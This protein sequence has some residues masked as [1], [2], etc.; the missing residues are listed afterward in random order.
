MSQKELKK[1]LIL[2]A[3]VKAMQATQFVNV[4][5]GQEVEGQKSINVQ[6]AGGWSFRVKEGDEY[7]DTVLKKI[8]RGQMLEIEMD[9][10]KIAPYQRTVTATDSGNEVS[11]TDYYRNIDDFKILSVGTTPIP[12][13]MKDV[14][15]AT[16]T[17]DFAR[18]KGKDFTQ[19]GG[20]GVGGAGTIDEAER[21]KDAL[22]DTSQ[23]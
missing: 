17:L 1:G 3:A 22:G 19:K 12:E 18:K 21:A 9:D 8:R 20:A 16:D 14:P 23:L 5:D 13:E 7:F 6:L 4:R 15:D 11:V 2:I 10:F